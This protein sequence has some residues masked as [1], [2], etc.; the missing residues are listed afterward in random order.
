MTIIDVIFASGVV[1][2]LGMAIV[3]IQYHWTKDKE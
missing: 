1:A 3:I 2:L